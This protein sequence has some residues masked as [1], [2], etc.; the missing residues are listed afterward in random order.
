MS[1]KSTEFEYFLVINSTLVAYMNVSTSDDFSRHNAA[2]SDYTDAI[3]DYSFKRANDYATD[4]FA[5]TTCTIEIGAFS[6]IALLIQVSLALLHSIAMSDSRVVSFGPG[7]IVLL[8]IVG[9]LSIDP[10]LVGLYRIDSSI[11]KADDS[12]FYPLQHVDTYCT[13]IV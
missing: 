4:V 11:D 12:A 7:A 1:K 9:I 13:Y 5:C 2:S 10:F 6:S 8:M 3:I